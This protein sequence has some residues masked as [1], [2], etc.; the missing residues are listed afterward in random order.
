MKRYCLVLLASIH[1]VSS[2]SQSTDWCIFK[3]G[4]LRCYDGNFNQYDHTLSGIDFRTS[5]IDRNGDLVYSMDSFSKTRRI[6]GESGPDF[7]YFRKVYLTGNSILGNRVRVTPTQTLLYFVN[8]SVKSIVRDTFILLN[9]PVLNETWTCYEDSL[10]QITGENTNLTLGSTP[11][12]VDSIR[13]IEIAVTVK[14]TNATLA[15][16]FEIGKEF[17]LLQCLDFGKFVR[18][19]H[20]T[21]YTETFHFLPYREITEKEFFTIK[22]GTETQSGGGI[23]EFKNGWAIQN[24]YKT[25]YYLKNGLLV[26]D[27]IR[28]QTR[29]SNYMDPNVNNQTNLISRDTTVAEAVVQKDTSSEIFNPLP[30][31]INTIAPY[32]YSVS[33]YCDS[34]YSV[35][36]GFNSG[37]SKVVR[38]SEDTMA[39]TYSEGDAE[40]YNWTSRSGVGVTSS[41]VTIQPGNISKSNSYVG[42]IKIDSCVIGEQFTKLNSISKPSYNAIKIYP[43][44]A[45]SSVILDGLNI[46]DSEAQIFDL[47]GK[48]VYAPLIEAHRLDVSGLATGI[49]M[50]EVLTDGKRYRGKFIKQ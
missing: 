48:Q 35:R 8:D 50:V 1:F 17:G 33:F 6:D 29:D 30:N 43:N 25:E 3:E 4:T 18:F 34:G 23:P 47:M 41:S 2:Y 14:K 42:Y 31:S 36:E 38:I 46:S 12:G 26:K 7:P 11:M 37:G 49:Y 40:F 27:V 39:I 22:S 5:Y 20:S 19:D 44:P 32:D 9:S 10:L 15:Y 13:T 24:Y 21:Y 16:T 45:S 28:I